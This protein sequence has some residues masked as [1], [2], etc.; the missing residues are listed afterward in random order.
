VSYSGPIIEHS[1]GARFAPYSLEYPTLSNH[2]EVRKSARDHSI[3]EWRVAVMLHFW[4][5]TGLDQDSGM[6]AKVRVL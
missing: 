2:L 4:Q 1:V 5:A 6:W 3:D